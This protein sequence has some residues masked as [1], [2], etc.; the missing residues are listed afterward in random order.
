MRFDE[1]G[2]E[3]AAE[4]ES[5]MGDEGDLVGLR[6]ARGCRCLAVR[7]GGE[8]AGYGWLSSGPEWIGELHM[9]IRPRPGEVYVWNCVTLPAYRGRGLFRALLEEAIQKAGREGRS[10][11]W[12]GTV[13][14]VGEASV[15]A[16][17]FTPV[18]RVQATELAGVGWLALSAPD[19]ADAGIVVHALAAL[20][21]GL[22]RSLFTP[23][24]IHPRRH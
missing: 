24:L 17:G 21:S 1:V 6:L 10:R 20:G 2:P 12:I 19:G 11:L 8:L 22:P 9:E 3:A 13:D 23:R 5:A 4:L 14:G 15:A 18:L 16:V 7:S